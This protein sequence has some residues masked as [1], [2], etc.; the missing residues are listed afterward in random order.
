M[1]LKISGRNIYW[2][3]TLW[4]KKNVGLSDK[5]RTKLNT[6]YPHVEGQINHLDAKKKKKQFWNKNS[7][8]KRP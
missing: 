6:D 7:E 2:K 3:Q 8:T 1:M 4:K 5:H